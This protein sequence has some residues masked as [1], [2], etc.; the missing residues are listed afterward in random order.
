MCTVGGD[1]GE[2]CKIWFSRQEW[3]DG[4]HEMAIIDS[5]GDIIGSFVVNIGEAGGEDTWTGMIQIIAVTGMV[6]CLGVYLWLR[7]RK[8]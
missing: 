6:I 2:G 3:V 5:D 1:A 4:S 7:P 8:E